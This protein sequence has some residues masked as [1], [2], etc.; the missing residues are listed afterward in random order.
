MVYFSIPS[1]YLEYTFY[2]VFYMLSI[3]RHVV[4]KEGRFLHHEGYKILKLTQ[5]QMV[6]L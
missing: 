5:A 4:E 1:K 3:H 6:V 2:L